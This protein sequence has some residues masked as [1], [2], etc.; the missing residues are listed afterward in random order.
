[1]IT[2]SAPYPQ[3]FGLPRRPVSD[4]DYA[5][6]LYA[7]TLVRDGGTLQI[8][9]GTLADALNHALVLR[10]TDNARYRRDFMHWTR[11]SPNTR[12]CTKPAGW[13]RSRSACTAAARCS[14]KASASWC[15]PA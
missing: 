6:G 11:S 14:T 2:P 3:L 1:M 7:S 12:W 9:I 13:G 10:H 5:I 4:A 8:G 15:R